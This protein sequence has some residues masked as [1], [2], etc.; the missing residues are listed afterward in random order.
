M[1]KFWVRLTQWEYWPFSVLYFPVY[2]YYIWLAAKRGS[3]FFFTASNP[4]IHFGGMFGEKKSEIFD[5][6]P[7][8]YMPRTFLIE[9]NQVEGAIDKAGTIGY[10]LIA[11][12]DIGERG[13][14]VKK[15]KDP[16]ELRAYAME[17][18]V[19]FL[20]QELVEFPLEL[21]VFYVRLPNERKGKVTSIVRKNFLSVIGD[22]NS[23]ILQLLQASDRA[24]LT[25]N[26]ESDFLKA[27]GSRIPKE[28]EE[29]LVEPIGNHSRGT[30]FLND[31][32][33]ITEK[34][35]EAVDRM[36]QEIPEFYFGRFDLR[37]TSYQDLA[38]LKN[39]KILELNGAGAEPGH[40]YQP[41]Y[42]L[43]KAYRDI[44]WHLKLLSK[45]SSQNHTKGVAYWSFREG[46]RNWKS[47]KR[48]NQILSA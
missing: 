19:D 23:S 12:P 24:L 44:L 22:G 13:I 21:G 29:V 11:K 14:W 35:S 7:D 41:G 9:K 48:Y 2:F 32:F 3:F 31:N 28:G 27:E 20:L 43:W 46:V 45:V 16:D 4:R 10:P 15:I 39:V 8:Q 26:L 30:Q 38:E 5:I 6:I 37:C 34:L 42:S 17:C 36:A 1:R 25:A 33:Q 18:P 47:H 40:I